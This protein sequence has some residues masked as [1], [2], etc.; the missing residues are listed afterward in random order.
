MTS[1]GR[2]DL[3]QAADQDPREAGQSFSVWT[4]RDLAHY[5]VQKGHLRVAGETVRRHL[6]NLGFRIVRPVLSI[7]SPD[8]DYDTKVERLEELKRSEEELKAEI[9]KA[10]ETLFEVKVEKVKVPARPA[11]KGVPNPFKPGEL[12]D[13]KAKKATTSR[14]VDA[15][16]QDR[17]KTPR[18]SPADQASAPATV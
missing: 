2:D 3:Q 1:A 14:A 10:V 12:M 7:A 16:S 9:K 4:C 8:P 11:R 5:L 6:W 17:R 15:P 18:S 13:V